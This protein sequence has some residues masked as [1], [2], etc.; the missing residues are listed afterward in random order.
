MR[1]TLLTEKLPLPE[2]GAVLPQAAWVGQQHRK[3]LPV[4]LRW[5]VRSEAS[6]PDLQEL[7]FK[8]TDTGGETRPRRHEGKG[9]TQEM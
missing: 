9:T 2:E 7:H 1:K 4:T 5:P 6:T 8:V 3:W